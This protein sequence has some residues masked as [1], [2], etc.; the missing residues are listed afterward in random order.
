MLTSISNQAAKYPKLREIDG[1]TLPICT[2]NNQ[3]LFSLILDKFVVMQISGK[4]D[5]ILAFLYR[6]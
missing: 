6:T 2:V 4:R 5:K 3:H 1:T